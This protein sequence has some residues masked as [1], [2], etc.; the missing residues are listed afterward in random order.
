MMNKM[1]KQPAGIEKCAGA[2]VVE[3]VLVLPLLILLALPIFDFARAIQANMILV[4]MSREGASLASRANLIYSDQQIMGA[5]ASTA[6]P[7]DMSNSGMIYITRVMGHA[8]NGGII[9]NVVLEQYRWAQGWNQSRYSPP[10]TVWNC[11]TSGTSWAT[12]GSCSN[13]PTGNSAPTA[14]VMTGQLADGEVIYAADVFYNFSTL[15]GGMNLG[16]G[17]TTPQLSHDLHAMTVL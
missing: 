6:S 15:F 2:A 9:R 12:G 8:E 7:L 10:S 16:F 14:N 13:I 11:G 4:N 3:F 17:L 5:L 1:N